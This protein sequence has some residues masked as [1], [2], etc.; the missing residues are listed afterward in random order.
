MITVPTWSKC[1]A[2]D[3]ALGNL[4][5][6]MQQNVVNSPGFDLLS[7]FRQRHDG[8][9]LCGMFAKSELLRDDDTASFV[10]SSLQSIDRELRRTGRLP[11]WAG[12]ADPVITIHY[13]ERVW[14]S[15][16]REPV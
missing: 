16:E 3:P 9:M 10:W 6:C 5:R 13:P 12:L 11:K 4:V 8:R 2:A 7:W 1:L 15:H 14:E